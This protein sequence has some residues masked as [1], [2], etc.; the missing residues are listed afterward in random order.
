MRE[1]GQRLESV[2]GDFATFLRERKLAL[3]KHQPYLVRRVREFLFFA[4]Q[5][6]GYTFEQTLDLFLAEMGHTVRWT[7]CDL[8]SSAGQI[9]K[10]S[11]LATSLCCCVSYSISSG[12]ES[13][14]AIS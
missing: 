13:E 12:P 2:L 6:G 8:A 9:V 4:R 10:P 3:P 1:G 7:T 11:F 14:I 5:H